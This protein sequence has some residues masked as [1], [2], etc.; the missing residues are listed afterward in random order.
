M[1]TEDDEKWH[2][3]VKWLARG[4]DFANIGIVLHIIV[5]LLPLL[6][7]FILPV[8]IFIQ[9]AHFINHFD[10]LAKGITA[11]A[12]PLIYLCKGSNRIVRLRGRKLGV[13]FIEEKYGRHP[14]QDKYDTISAILFGLAI[15]AFILS[16]FFFPF[17]SPVA[18]V[19]GLFGTG[20]NIYFDET[21]PAERAAATYNPHR[22]DKIEINEY[23]KKHYYESI[24]Y[25]LLLISLFVF[26]PSKALAL[27]NCFPKFTETFKIIAIIGCALVVLLNLIRV[28]NILPCCSAY[29]KLP[30][31]EQPVE[32]DVSPSS[33]SPPPTPCSTRKIT[34]R[35]DTKSNHT[36]PPTFHNESKIIYK[37]PISRSS[38]SNDLAIPLTPRNNEENETY[39][40]SATSSSST[41]ELEDLNHPSNSLSLRNHCIIL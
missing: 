15:T 10:A 7:Q 20:I 11:I 18:W 4:A 1:A 16:H 29:Q 24:F 31:L 25:A 14:N 34:P 23:Y 3:K 5:I 36:P 9:C 26:L 17:L 13:E 6:L 32:A 39:N 12:D 33:S 40:S 22:E 21:Y 2:R 19:A 35:L 37:L 30:G 38:S 28:S 27:S 8:T 41:I